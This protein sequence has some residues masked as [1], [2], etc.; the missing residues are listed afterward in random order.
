M[1]VVPVYV[2]VV[3]VMP[4][5]L[6]QLHTSSRELHVQPVGQLYCVPVAPVAAQQPPLP[7]WHN[8]PFA[9][10][11]AESQ[12]NSAAAIKFVGIIAIADK[13]PTFVLGNN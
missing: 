6:A 9:Q 8:E 13:K 11:E 12:V 4:E 3:S 7:A 1:H 10:S 5:T 2:P